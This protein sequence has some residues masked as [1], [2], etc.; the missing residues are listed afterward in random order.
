MKQPSL[1]LKHRITQLE[2]KARRVGTAIVVYGLL[3]L[4]GYVFLFPILKMVSQSF[5]DSRDIVDP[6]ILFIPSHLSFANFVQAWQTMSMPGSLFNSVWLSFLLASFQAVSSAM[7]GY[8]FARFQFR[9]KMLL[10]FLV[11]ATYI[12]PVQV[13]VIPRFMVFSFYD[14]VGSVLPLLAVAFLGQGLSGPIFILIFRNFFEMLPPSIDEAAQIDGASRFQTFVRITLAMSVPILI[15]CFLFSFVWNWNETYVTGLVAA[16]KFR[17][18]PLELE[19]FVASYTRLFIKPGSQTSKINEAIRMA[20]T[21]VSIAPLLLIYGFLQRQF[22]EGI[23]K[24]GI[25]GE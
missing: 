3:V 5:M 24:T 1:A 16:G 8:A 14:L 13:L 17:T 10:M 2:Q 15:V 20:G 21:L 22:V 12:I 9:G 23:E 11:L 6:N 19:G 7:A 25:T 18:L 4:I